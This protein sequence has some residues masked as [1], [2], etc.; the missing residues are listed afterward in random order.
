MPSD[1]CAASPVPHRCRHLRLTHKLSLDVR[2]AARTTDQSPYLDYR[3]LEPQLVARQ[4]GAPEAHAIDPGKV[5]DFFLRMFKSSHHEH[6]AHLRHRLD[7]EHARH[8]RV[9]RKV[10]AK[11]RLVDGDVLDADNPCPGL[12]L[13]N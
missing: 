13:D 11:E 7:D 9:A 10:A 1:E 8:D 5:D 4:D 3:D 6:P 2:L 12:H